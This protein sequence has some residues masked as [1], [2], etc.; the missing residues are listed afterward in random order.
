MTFVM[1]AQD[2]KHFWFVPQFDTV[3]I[4]V[5][6]AWGNM[7]VQEWV[8]VECG[9]SNSADSKR[10]GK[11][12]SSS[13]R[14]THVSAAL[15]MALIGGLAAA[16]VP[17]IALI[18][19]QAECHYGIGTIA[20]LILF[21]AVIFFIA[22]AYVTLILAV[23][24]KYVGSLIPREK[25][26]TVNDKTVLLGLVT[27]SIVILILLDVVLDLSLVYLILPL[28]VTTALSILI[29]VRLANRLRGPI[30]Y[31]VKW[32]IYGGAVGVSISLLAGFIL[33]GLSLIADCLTD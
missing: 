25:R 1:G 7:S 33:G 4:G 15:F 10:C 31:S 19:R 11:C 24:T 16:L 6:N 3:L 13:R 9:A 23:G 29:C 26:Q 5:H 21:V 20:G 28:I 30:S 8:C 18:I 14:F 12:K 32:I 22:G 2:K 17:V 27:L